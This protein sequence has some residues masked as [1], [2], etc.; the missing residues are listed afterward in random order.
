MYTNSE[1]E[2]TWFAPA[3]LNP[4]LLPI[5][6]C[7]RLLRSLLRNPPKNT[8]IAIDKRRL[9]ARYRCRKGF[10]LSGEQDRTCKNGRWKEKEPK[11]LG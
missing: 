7:N 1:T 2:S 5:S 8:I 9:K 10:K 6:G 3:T 4:A 11:C